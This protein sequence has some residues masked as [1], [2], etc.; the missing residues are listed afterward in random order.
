MMNQ[1]K[2]RIKQSKQYHKDSSN[3]NVNIALVPIYAGLKHR[4]LQDSTWEVYYNLKDFYDI[5]G[6]LGELF[7]SF[8]GRIDN[9]NN[10]N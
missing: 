10:Q 4:G 3:K 9:L 7:E 1:R 2:M 8:I 6:K 5:Q